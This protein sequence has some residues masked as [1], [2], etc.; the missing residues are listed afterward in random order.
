MEEINRM[1]QASGIKEELSMENK[2]I[3]LWEH[4]KKSQASTESLKK[5]CEQQ[6]EDMIQVS[7]IAINLYD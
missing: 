3:Y 5:Q 7:I 2:L 6:S 4:L 1:L